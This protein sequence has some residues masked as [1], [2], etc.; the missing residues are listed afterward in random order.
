MLQE[1]DKLRNKQLF[2]AVFLGNNKKRKRGEVEF[3][4]LDEAEK[5]KIRAIER[6]EQL[7]SEDEAD[8]ID[9]HNINMQQNLK[10]L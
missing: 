10:Q 4:E 8:E 6:R 9:E 7:M 5:R 1:D 3:E 2:S